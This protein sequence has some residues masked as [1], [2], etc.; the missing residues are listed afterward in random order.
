MS[1]FNE[2]YK[3]YYKIV[4]EA[5]A[6]DRVKLK[7]DHSDYEYFENH[8]VIPESLGGSNNWRN[9]VLLTPEEHYICHSLL[10]D[11]CEGPAHYKMIFAWNMLNKVKGI[12]LI[13]GEEVL[14]AETYG[15]LSRE[16][17]EI[18]RSE[19]KAFYQ[20]EEGKKI[21]KERGLKLSAY[22]QTEEGKRKAKERGVNTSQ[23]LQDF[24]QTE[25]GKEV[26]MLRGITNGKTQQEFAQT[27]EGKEYYKLN[28]ELQKIFNQTEEGKAIRARLDNQQRE[29]A[30]TDEG[31]EYYLLK[32][33]TQKIFNQTEEGKEFWRRLT[34]NNSFTKRTRSKES[35][36]KHSNTKKGISTG[37]FT[38]ERKDN[39]SKAA[40]GRKWYKN[41]SGTKSVHVSDIV[42]PCY[43]LFGW[44]LGR[45]FTKSPK[46]TP[47][48]TCP[49]CGRSFDPGNYT[50][51]INK[52][53]KATKVTG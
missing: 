21:A 37:P 50:Q 1:K 38:Q 41:A 7:R 19:R 15:I 5:R 39:I 44:T 11:F 51:H 25:E 31:K 20:T 22:Y 47:K 46:N 35:K 49:D 36:L 24:Y 18:N 30:Q 6:L 26:A 27:K 9:M 29:F 52:Y 12:R 4:K 14:G 16:Y 2:S 40:L 10:P 34:Q 23:I 43:T 3:E 53:C 13:K 17:A 28:G 45:V 42:A 33:E 32:G 8:H 48:K